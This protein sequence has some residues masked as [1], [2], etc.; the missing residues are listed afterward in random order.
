LGYTSFIPVPYAIEELTITRANYPAEYGQF[1]GAHINYTMKSGTNS[2]HGSAF[3]Y[4]QN[5]ALNARNYSATSKPSL[6]QNLYGFVIGGPVKKNNTFFLVSYQG[7]RYFASTF[8]QGVT[9]T[10]A[11]RQGDLSNFKTA[12]IDP[13]AGSPFAGNQIPVSRFVPQALAALTIDPLPNQTGSYNYGSF[14]GRPTYGNGGFVKVDHSFGANDRLSGWLL[15]NSTSSINT[16]GNAARVNY[17]SNRS[18]PRILH[19]LRPRHSL[20]RW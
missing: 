1:A 13:K 11:E 14:V 19:L 2:L 15:I 9:A 7:N 5:D 10:A 17:L 12:I 6:R 18:M 8:V 4:F 20:Q 16:T 3:E